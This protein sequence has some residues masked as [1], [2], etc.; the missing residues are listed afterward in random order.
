MFKL[1]KGKLLHYIKDD[2][3]RHT[4][5]VFVGT[6]IVGVFNL[7]Y[8]LI[9]VRLLTPEDYG[10]FN[11]L[12]SLIMFASMTVFPLAP[13]LTRFFTEYITKKDFTRLRLVFN[14]F[15]KR[16]L[17]IAFF[18]LFIFS[19]FSIPLAKFFKTQP[20]YIVI[21]GIITAVSLI[22]LPFPSLFQSLQKFKILSSVSILSSL[23]KLITGALLMYIGWGVLGGLSGYLI[24]PLLT[25]FIYIFF[26][27][28][29]FHKEIT[30]VD[31]SSLSESV[32]LVPIYKY[33]LPVS[34]TMF[35][36]IIL[37]NIDVILVKHFFS[38]LNAGYYSIAQI[39]GKIFLFLPSAL[40]VVMFP[41]STAAYINNSHSHKILYKSL[42][43]AS[44]LCGIGIIVC[45]LFPGLVLSI[46]T[47]KANPVSV[48]L[49]G[50]FSLA[51][52]FYALLWLVINYLIA[53]HNLKIAL[54]LLF[55]AGCEAISI[56][57]WHP[58]LVTVLYTLVA[59]S[60][61]TFFISLY[62]VKIKKE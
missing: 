13:T 18:F 7:I 16:L 58:S 53:T 15:A 9:S 20:V 12:I 29:V 39:V 34:I 19:V 44:I 49:V 46:L 25:L 17:V 36:F 3:I 43:L 11:A 61:V 37:I 23:G 26:V 27:S 50:L 52:T 57:A 1:L 62:F 14:K 24:A 38:P 54:F 6:S 48:R 8:H 55:L 22:S 4:A 56:Y 31:K 2:L 60:I 28:N 41:K 45:F 30:D 47:S 21:C 33:F 59:F 51:M 40:A 5:I 42:L 32:D 35:S 10:T